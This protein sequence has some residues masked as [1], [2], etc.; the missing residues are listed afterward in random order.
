LCLYGF[1]S[2]S[3][4]LKRFQTKIDAFRSDL[5]ISP[6]ILIQHFAVASL[7]IAMVFVHWEFCQAQ[8]V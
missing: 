2:I 3:C 6:S 7:M 1:D 8:H 5:F 4:V